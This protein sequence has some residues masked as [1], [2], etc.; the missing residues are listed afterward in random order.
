MFESFYIFARIKNLINKQCL[1]I[2]LL[3]RWLFV[4]LLA[5]LLFSIASFTV[6]S[7]S[8]NEWLEQNFVRLVENHEKTQKIIKQ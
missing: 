2:P 5:P 1:F 8:L 6:F 7:L 4:E 3:D